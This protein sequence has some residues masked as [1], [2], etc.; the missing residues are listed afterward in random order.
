MIEWFVFLPFWQQL[1]IIIVGA[2]VSLTVL[3]IIIGK[4]LGMSNPPK[5]YSVWDD[6]Q[7][8][9]DKKK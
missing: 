4:F 3:G 5:D 9:T 6:L 8:K 1:M 2:G 7:D